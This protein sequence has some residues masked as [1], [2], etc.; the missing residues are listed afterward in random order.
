MKKNELMCTMSMQEQLKTNGGGALG[1][2]INTVVD[3]LTGK[4]TLYV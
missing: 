3:A 2:L 1:L 4:I